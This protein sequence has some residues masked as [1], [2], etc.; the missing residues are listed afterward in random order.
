MNKDKNYILEN[1]KDCFFC[2]VKRVI[3]LIGTCSALL[4]IIVGFFGKIIYKLTFFESEN[5]IYSSLYLLV[6]VGSICIVIYTIHE[7]LRKEIVIKII[8]GD[9]ENKIIIK[10]GNYEDNMD[11]IL[12]KING[13]NKQAI[14]IVG[15]NDKIDMTIAERNGVHKAVL[16]KFYCQEEQFNKFQEKVYKS[17]EKNKN[18]DGEFGDIGLVEH[19][20]NSKIMFVINS[21][22]EAEE[23]TS[24][25]GPQPA[26]VLDKVFEKLKKEKIEI[27]QIPILSSI[28]IKC[29]NNSIR[30]SV[31][32]AEIIDRYFKE[33]LNPN[34]MNY[35]LVLSI[36]KEDLKKKS[37]T[38]NHIVK[39]INNIKYMYH[40]K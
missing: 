1:L 4:E 33:V 10:I 19:N 24:I 39:F 13:T 7:F 9:E 14:F 26:E 18:L 23:S 28:N 38:A 34:N 8:H 22:Y 2:I 11:E 21:K 17:F 35:D 32:I 3:F 5:D 25:I 27:V 20:E 36:R 40:I 30:Y 29:N 16:K 15:I 31:T 37:I 12:N 6:F